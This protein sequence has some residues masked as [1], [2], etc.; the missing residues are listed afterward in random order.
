MD[1]LA[2]VLISGVILLTAYFTFGRWLSRRV[3]Q[4]D[5]ANPTPAVTEEDGVD[6]VPT[7]KSVIFGHHFTSIAGTG[8][9][10]G[11]AIAVIWGWLPAILWVVLGSIFIGAVHDLGSMVA[12]L[13]NKGR[14]IGDIAGDI[15]GPRARFIFLLILI[16]GL[17][18][19]L[20]VFGLVIATVL[21]QYPAAV[22]PVLFQIPIAVAI[23]VFI[24]RKGRS[25]VPA[26][27]IALA[28][29]YASVV[30]GDASFGPTL[31]GL[32][33]LNQW[34]AAQP[35]WIWT[36]FLL[37]YAYIASVIPVW[38]LLQPRDYINALQLIT[39]LALIVLGLIA[40]AFFG[41]AA[42][43]ALSPVAVGGGGGGVMRSMTEGVS[44]RPPL[45]I[46]APLVNWQPEGAPPIFPLLFITV[47]CGACS[48][49]HCL[50][51]S[52][53]T[54]KQIHKE[55]DAKAV[56]YGSMLTEGFLATLVIAACAAGIGLGVI[57]PA[58]EYRRGSSGNAFVQVSG[59]VDLSH[60][61]EEWGYGL[62]WYG[63]VVSP[64]S[65]LHVE[66]SRREK[67]YSDDPQDLRDP[68]HPVILNDGSTI[69]LLQVSS[70]DANKFSSYHA[71]GPL[72]FHKQYTSWSSSQ[73]LAATVG[74]FVQ[75]SANFLAAL[76]IP[77][78]LAVALMAVMVAS[79]AATTMDTACR[80]QRYVI[81]ELSRT[82][83]PSAPSVACKNCG[84]DLSSH[85]SSPVAD[86]GGVTQSVTEGVAQPSPIT[87]PECG[88]VNTPDDLNHPSLNHR[89][90]VALASVFNPFK[91]LATT[92]GATIFAVLTAFIL[93]MWGPWPE[94]T[95]WTNTGLGGTAF[96]A[97]RSFSEQL[98][99]W[100][101]N[102]GK[103]G[104]LL[105]PL[106]GA[107]NQLLAGFAFVVIV[108]WLR[109]TRR[110]WWFAII[111]AAFMLA[112]PAAAMSW[113]AFIG[114]EQ[115]PSWLAEQKWL[116][117]S[118]AC[119][120]LALEAWLIIETMLHW[121]RR[122]APSPLDGEGGRA[123]TG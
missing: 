61:S 88:R 7:R 48:G 84:Y 16:V 115:N 64:Q 99:L 41:G 25:I 109:F 23:G 29:M 77:L 91:W 31:G 39:S 18:I 58:D 17:W 55:R 2:L 83:L 8:P 37:I 78:S 116:L 106:F 80:L 79:F 68:S 38:T 44:S 74:A 32:H 35:I 26:S 10:V 100:L 89:A 112:V 85:T 82:F 22:F 36:A 1:A 4:L 42:F 34:A 21:K 108:A 28:L 27:I 81:Q 14:S 103:G 73:G 101:A 13:R 114:N 24:H 9:I 57:R 72:A 52:G 92:H 75:G 15:L 76:G 119:T 117:L 86:G 56:G 120:T 40:A 63:S 20:A 87:C 12:S 46:V 51:G 5:D 33:A 95:K 102:G 90:R 50:V 104:L 105:W 93:A 60:L 94:S 45:S 53:T 123:A 122:S 98:Q 71:T 59:E 19:V 107:T 97:T 54:S 65:D 6:F 121:K 11:P 49:F 96:Q 70:I 43:D 110:P 118:V 111:P 113:Q 66:L 47:A 30:F 67:F 62:R 3:F 69:T